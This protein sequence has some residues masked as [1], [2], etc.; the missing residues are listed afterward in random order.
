M[1]AP[2]WSWKPHPRARS[3]RLVR[4]AL[5]AGGTAPALWILYLG[6]ADQLGAD[7]MKALERELG[8]WALRFLIAGL[9]ITPL[10]QL[11]GINLLTFRRALGLLAFFYVCLHLTTYL[12]L[13]Q[14]LDL[15]AIWADIVKRPY[16]TVGMFGF[17]VM[18]PLAITS[19][20]AVIRRIGSQAWTR[21]HRLVYVAAAAGAVHFVLLVKSWPAEPLIYAAIVLALLGYRVARTAGAIPARKRAGA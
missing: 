20:N 8:I 10:R 21:L 17:L 6:I 7:P 19:H 5:Y 1:P 2:A 18:V 13:D 11:T 14:R 4:I 15:A 12:W 9:T 3:T 16:I